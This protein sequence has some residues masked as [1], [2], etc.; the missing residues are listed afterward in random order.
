MNLL[1]DKGFVDINIEDIDLE[2]K[3]NEINFYMFWNLSTIVNL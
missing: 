2:I 3:K 1:K